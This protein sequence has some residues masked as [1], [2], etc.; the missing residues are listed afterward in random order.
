MRHQQQQQQR[1][2]MSATTSMFGLGGVKNNTTPLF[3]PFLGRKKK[4]DRKYQITGYPQRNSTPRLVIP[5]LLHPQKS[6]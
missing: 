4:A 3:C 5:F 2:H 6:T 1:Y